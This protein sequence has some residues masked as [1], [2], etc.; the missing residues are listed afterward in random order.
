MRDKE[1]I[2][3]ELP[4]DQKQAFDHC[5]DLGQIKEAREILVGH[6][7]DKHFRMESKRKRSNTMK[8]HKVP[9]I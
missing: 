1:R 7:R 8:E 2:Y 9:W 3:N 4:E 6:R 5:L